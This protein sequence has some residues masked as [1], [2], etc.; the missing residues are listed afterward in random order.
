MKTPV[1]ESNRRNDDEK[2]LI[3]RIGLVGH[4]PNVGGPSEA[5]YRLDEKRIC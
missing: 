4:H 1:E 3:V 5:S 2:G